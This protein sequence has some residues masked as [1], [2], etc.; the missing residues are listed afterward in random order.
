MDKFFKILIVII[1]LITII[2]F[3]QIQGLKKELTHLKEIKTEVRV[4]LQEEKPA[5]EEIIYIGNSKTLKFHLP[6]CQWAKKI[7]LKN[8]V[9]FKSKREAQERGYQPCKVCRP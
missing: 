6:D 9:Y 3:F 1:F 4:N 7:S 8:R 2:N 5:E